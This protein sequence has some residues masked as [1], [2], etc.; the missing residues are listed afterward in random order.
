MPPT[1]STPIVTN[2]KA[3]IPDIP[4][5]PIGEIKEE[6]DEFD[7]SIDFEIIQPVKNNFDLSQ[8]QKNRL[9]DLNSKI[10]FQIELGKETKKTGS[11]NRPGSFYLRKKYHRDRKETIS[12]SELKLTPKIWQSKLDKFNLFKFYSIEDILDGC[13]TSGR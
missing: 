8:D 5:S 9:A 4:L 1:K 6:F 11:A 12:L 7:E 10:K 3:E 2:S 13:K